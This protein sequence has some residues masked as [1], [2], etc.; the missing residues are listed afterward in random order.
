MDEVVARAQREMRAQLRAVTA[1]D[2]ELLALRADRSVARAK[3]T[4]PRGGNGLAPGTMELLV[5]PAAAESLQGGRLS[6]LHIDRQFAKMIGDYLDQYRLLTTILRVREPHYVGIQVQARIVPSEYSRSE[7]VASRVVE[8][9]RAFLSPL[10]LAQGAEDVGDLVDGDWEGWPFGRDLYVAEI[11]S[12]I[13]RVPGV[14][15]VLDVRLAQRPVFPDQERALED[16]SAP[17]DV[18]PVLEPVEQNLV[19]VPSNALIC[20]LDHQITLVELEEADD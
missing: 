13:Q 1:E 16:D 8:Q 11:F 10:P 7:V 17:P 19:R 14:K 3:C 12:L 18:E 6:N 9:L 20:S 15:H 2:Y 5:V 4:M